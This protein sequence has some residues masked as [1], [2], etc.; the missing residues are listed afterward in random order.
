MKFKKKSEVSVGLVQ[1][2]MKLSYIQTPPCNP[3]FLDVLSDSLAYNWPAWW[4]I[5]LWEGLRQEPCSPGYWFTKVAPLLPTN[6]NWDRHYLYF[7]PDIS[8]YDS[9]KVSYLFKVTQQIKS[10]AKI[11]IQVSQSPKPMP[12]TILSL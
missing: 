9:E 10:R 3:K 4:A 5:I 6:S 8:N 2:F 12:L 11:K 1:P 7:F